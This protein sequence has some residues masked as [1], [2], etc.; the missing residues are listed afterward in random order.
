MRDLTNCTLARFIVPLRMSRTR[1]G[2]S[3]VERWW[4]TT[5]HREKFRIHNEW[6]WYQNLNL[7]KRNCWNHQ[8][9]YFSVLC[10]DRWECAWHQQRTEF[11]LM[12]NQLR[13]RPYTRLGRFM[14]HQRAIFSTYNQ[15]WS[16]LWN[17]SAIDWVAGTSRRRSFSHTCTLAQLIIPFA[18]HIWTINTHNGD[19]HTH[20]RHPAR[21]TVANN[22]TPQT[23]NKTTAHT[24]LVVDNNNRT[25][26]KKYSVSLYSLRT[27]ARSSI[28]IVRHCVCVPLIQP[29]KQ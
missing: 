6:N 14:N 11:K 21:C 3:R 1:A 8:L 17:I 7:S 25:N 5:S 26:V 28:V 16:S 29:S 4:R 13:G 22:A 9:S 24:H 23:H 10:H 19:T 2:D 15:K 20:A 18:E 27:C 12:A